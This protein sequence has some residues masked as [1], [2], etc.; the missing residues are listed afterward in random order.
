[1]AVCNILKDSLQ[2]TGNF[3]LFSQY[4]EDLA[5]FTAEGQ[6][7]RV[8]PSKFVAMDIDYSSFNSI[9]KTEITTQL[10]S[11]G[12]TDINM[13]QIML[14]YLQDH[15][16]NGCSYV[17]NHLSS[18]EQWAPVYYASFFKQSRWH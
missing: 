14:T 7:Y 13:D 8:A 15:F 16:E 9:L 18:D 17:K 3:I 6:A 2:S 5:R 1:M 10:E 4:M 12:Y 11:S